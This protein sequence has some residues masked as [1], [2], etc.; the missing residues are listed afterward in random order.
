MCTHIYIYI[1]ISL[2]IYIYTPISTYM[3]NIYIYI[4][5]YIYIHEIGPQ[6]PL[7]AAL[8]G[9]VAP[10]RN[11]LAGPAPWRCYAPTETSK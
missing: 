2:Y 9:R 10:H 8:N 3:Y 11:G 1:C 5:I 6:W 4:Y 7:L